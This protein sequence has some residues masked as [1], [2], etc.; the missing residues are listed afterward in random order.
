[1][2]V[3]L[4]GAVVTGAHAGGAE[5]PSFLPERAN[6]SSPVAAAV[7]RLWTHPTFSRTVESKPADLPLVSYLRFVDA[8][9]L[10]AAAARHLGV[11]RYEV[12]ARGDGWYEADDHDGARG[13]YLVLL[14]QGGRR[15]IVSWGTHRSAILGAVSGTALTLLEFEDRRGRTA[16]RLTAYVDIE[17][18]AA[19]ALTR[20]LLPVFGGIVD[21]KLVEG[22]TVTARVAAWARSEPDGFC[23]WL[24]RELEPGRR[25]ELLEVFREC[26]FGRAEGP[27]GVTG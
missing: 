1:V 14:R 21:R 17:N 10:T 18:R 25:E 26:P 3:L 13:V 19:A 9:D 6:Y 5:W 7:Q 15:A 8:P 27:D 16:Q 12:H 20:L 24:S 4:P 2:L 11:A 22:F 23:A